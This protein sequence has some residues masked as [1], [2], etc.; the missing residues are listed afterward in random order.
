MFMTKTIQKHFTIIDFTL[1]GSLRKK[2]N[3]HALSPPIASLIQL[4]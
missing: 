2:Q 4:S 1:T 3:I